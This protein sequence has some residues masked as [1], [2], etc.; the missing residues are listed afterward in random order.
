R[1][2]LA[3]VAN[4]RQYIPLARKP[5]W[6]AFRPNSAENLAFLS[7]TG[8]GTAPAVDGRKPISLAPGADHEQLRS[9]LRFPEPALSPGRRAARRPRAPGRRPVPDLSQKPTGRELDLL[10]RRLLAGRAFH[11][12]RHGI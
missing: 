8:T 1:R 6:T 9:L 7:G 4:Y 3:F 12:T 11:L 10:R 5:H 2:R